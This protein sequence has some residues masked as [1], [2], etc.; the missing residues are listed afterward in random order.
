MEARFHEA[1]NGYFI[2]D[3]GRFGFGY[4]NHSERPRAARVDGEHVRWEQ[5][6]EAA[7]RRLTDLIHHFGPKAVAC[8]GSLRSSVETQ[9]MLKRWC[10]LKGL[11]EPVY[12][13]DPCIERK[14]R[15]AVHRLD[16]QIAVSLREIE[17]SDFI[18]AIGVDPINEAPMLALAMRQA[19]CNGATVV[20]IDPRPVFLPH[21]FVHVPVV[22]REIGMCLGTLI[23]AAVSR[24]TAEELCSAALRFYDAIPADYP[25]D[26]LI[27]NRLKELA[28]QLRQS[29]RPVLICGTD[30]VPETMPALAA[31]HTL[32][33]HAARGQAGLFYLLPGANGFGAA[34]L[35][36]GSKDFTSILETIE[37][38]TVRA[39]ILVENDPFRVF[40]D[41]QRLEQAISKLDLLLVL[42]YVPSEAAHYAHIM[43]PTR[44]LFESQGGFINQEGR[45]QFV[46]PVH[47]GGIPI[48]QISAGQHPPRSFRPDIPGAE[49]RPAWM[50]LAELAP[51][52]FP[53]ET[54][55][56]Q[57]TIWEWLAQK[58]PLFAQ[59][60][61]LGESEMEVK[62]ALS[63]D[64]GNEFTLTDPTLPE[65][66]SSRADELE[67]L[68]VEWTFGTEELSSYSK[69]TQQVE[70]TPR[71]FM[72]EQDAARLRL[73][74]GDRVSMG[75][76][77][78]SL[79][80]ELRVV[81]NMAQGIMV[82]PRH[83]ELAWQKMKTLP[84]V[85]PIERIEK[86]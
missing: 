79:E 37:D 77:E 27:D 64:Q 53:L 18:I 80:L 24:S 36:S 4:T 82:V 63:R 83:R 34:L 68:L 55:A 75:L 86:V 13:I 7:L 56:L 38:G 15:Q 67:L 71:L 52:H 12:F 29:C 39:L 20:L 48:V 26:P 16:S 43:L 76:D 45:L 2:C 31:D 40:P 6:V 59:A 65:T 72:Q 57:R 73:K 3:R 85:I 8:V 22:P 41:R 11:E 28:I 54:Q 33:L 49:A 21:G 66:P 17:R 19:C 61:P 10:Q 69:P 78:G 14:V 32:L 23:K 81:E 25:L 51:D 44:T 47:L 9:A 30:I 62:L 46:R 35:S 42:D 5:A 50:A 58:D 60:Q 1:V 84:V 74:T 70:Q